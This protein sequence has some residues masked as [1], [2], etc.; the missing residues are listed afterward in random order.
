MKNIVV[1]LIAGAVAGFVSSEVGFRRNAGRLDRIETRL[2][3]IDRNL[4]NLAAQH[5]K[6][7]T[8][9]DLLNK[10][11]ASESRAPDQNARP[12]SGFV[13]QAE[14]AALRASTQESLQAV[15]E[16][17]DF[18]AEQIEELHESFLTAEAD[19]ALHADKIATLEKP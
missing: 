5:A 13:G 11:A 7:E 12:L 19:I 8:A 1:L 6:M 16:A 3:A 4:A 17:L 2:G 10:I 9:V 15:R 14:L 18:H